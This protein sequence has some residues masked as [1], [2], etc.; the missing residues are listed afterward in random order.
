LIQK[1]LHTRMY[2]ATG[3]VSKGNTAIQGKPKS[4]TKALK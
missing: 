2:R 4:N 3:K 1:W